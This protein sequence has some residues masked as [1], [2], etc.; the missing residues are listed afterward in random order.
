MPALYLT[1]VTR[2]PI[3][4]RF[5]H[6]VTSRSA[7]RVD[8]RWG[9]WMQLATG[10]RWF[11]WLIVACQSFLTFNS[12]TS[13]ATTAIVGHMIVFKKRAGIRGSTYKSMQ[14]KTR[15]SS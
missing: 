9:A 12:T 5:T 11:V 2:F 14:L 13:R 10:C 8:V 1:V 7:A 4:W 3:A 15:Y 6:P